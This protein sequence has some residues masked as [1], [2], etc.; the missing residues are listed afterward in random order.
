MQFMY[1]FSAVHTLLYASLV[2]ARFA[3]VGSRN[4]T[5]AV[6][7]EGGSSTRPKEPWGEKSAS[8]S[9]TSTSAGRFFT[10]ITVVLL[11]AAACAPGDT[12]GRNL[13]K[14]SLSESHCKMFRRNLA[15]THLTKGIQTHTIVQQELSSLLDNLG[16]SQSHPYCNTSL[17]LLQRETK[18]GWSN[19]Q[20]EG[21]CWDDYGGCREFQI[22]KKGWNVTHMVQNLA[23]CGIIFFSDGIC[24]CT[25]AQKQGVPV[26]GAIKRQEIH[27]TKCKQNH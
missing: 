24:H 4:S 25:G 14:K 27:M 20:I 6:R 11:A 19:K 18:T 13:N 23:F 16:F 2:K 9:D 7:P 17:W 10:R 3:S 1:R 22:R 5:M 26:V 15:T 8:S 12:S 21:I